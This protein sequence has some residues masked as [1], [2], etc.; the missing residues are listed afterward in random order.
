MMDYIGHPIYYLVDRTGVGD[1]WGVYELWIGG[2]YR[3]PFRTKEDAI[4][5]EEL[6]AREAGWKLTRLE[7]VNA[8]GTEESGR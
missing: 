3:G 7:R 1:T 8:C 6:L 4:K 5:R 2:M